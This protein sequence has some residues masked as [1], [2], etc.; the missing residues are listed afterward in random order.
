M[1]LLIIEVETWTDIHHPIP[2]DDRLYRMAVTDPGGASVS[3]IIDNATLVI[4]VGPDG[5]YLITHIP[6]PARAGRELLAGN[7]A[8]R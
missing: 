5:A 1:A 4:E 2:L 6:N 3:L 7:L 8:H